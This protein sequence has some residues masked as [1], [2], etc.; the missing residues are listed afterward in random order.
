M[1]KIMAQEVVAEK[2]TLKNVIAVIT[3]KKPREN[4]L[5]FCHAF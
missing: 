4:R 1:E 5:L 2:G 3:V